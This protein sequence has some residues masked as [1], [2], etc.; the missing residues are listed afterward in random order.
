MSNMFLMKHLD[1]LVTNKDALNTSLKDIY[2][3]LVVNTTCI[4]PLDILCMLRKAEKS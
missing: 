1:V 2:L 3:F 4:Y